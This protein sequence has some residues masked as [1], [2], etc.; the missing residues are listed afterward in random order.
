MTAYY[1]QASDCETVEIDGEWMILHSGQFTITKLNEMGG[2]CWSL[3]KD[4]H[5]L[6]ELILSYIAEFNNTNAENELQCFLKELEKCGLIE[7]AV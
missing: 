2:Y 7:H 3:L 1:K 6:D 4:P 5:T